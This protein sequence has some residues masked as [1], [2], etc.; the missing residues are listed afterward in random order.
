MKMRSYP[1]IFILYP[2]QSLSRAPTSRTLFP[3]SLTRSLSLT[4]T[5]TRTLDHC[6]SVF[7]QELLEQATLKS[8]RR[9]SSLQLSRFHWLTWWRPKAPITESM[10]MYVRVCVR[11][12]VCMHAHTACVGTC[13]HACQHLTTHTVRMGCYRF[14]IRLWKTLQSFWGQK[15]SCPSFFL[16]LSSVF[17]PTQEDP[18]QWSVKCACVWVCVKIDTSWFHRLPRWQSRD[19]ESAGVLPVCLNLNTAGW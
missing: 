8:G 7:A 3:L 15:P 9:T 19:A 6:W 13:L 2:T 16:L 12:C 1:L 17:N 4:H 14:H 18:H 10:C 11:V 5:H